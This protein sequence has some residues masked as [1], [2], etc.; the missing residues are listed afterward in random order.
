MSDEQ[1]PV[2]GRGQIHES[3][4]ATIGETPLVRMPR[5][6]VDAG[7]E[8]ELLA[9]LEAF[10]PLSS[11]KDRIALAMVDAAE[12]DGRIVPGESTLIEPTSGNT[13]IA[14]AFIAAA[15]G[16]RL[17]L[18]MPANM[19]LE[20]RKLFAYYGARVELTEP[21]AG[22]RGAIERADALLNQ[23]PGSFQPAQFSN[24]ANPQAHRRTTAEE[25]WRDTGGEVDGLIAGVG[26][27]GALTGIAGLLKERRPGF[28]AHAVEPAG[29]PVL[30]GGAPGPHGLQGIGAGFIP[31]TLDPSLI[32][33][34]H[35]VE[36]EEALQT[37]RYVSR[38]EGIPC[39]ISSG[40]ALAAAL[41]IASRPGLRGKRLVVLLASSA[42]RYLSTPLF[43]GL[44]EDG[45]A[46]AG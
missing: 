27:G 44:D 8:A 11:V 25:I 3:F 4:L 7:L 46:A 35:P 5:L 21:A 20:R 38:L 32:D 33:E 6:S 16:Y 39:G 12:A 34:I 29:S 13:G 43:E 14:L 24:P 45:S 26:T 31:E 30:A 15:R 22:M 19:S 42:E 10:N 36:D 9:K 28:R 37:A 40:A 18:T 17:I 1:A 41:H 23:I 2:S